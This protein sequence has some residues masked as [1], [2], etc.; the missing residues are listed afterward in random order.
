MAKQYKDWFTLD[1]RVRPGVGVSKAKTEAV[2]DLAAQAMRGS[3][4]ALGALTE[5]VTTSDA[6]FNLAH[7]VTLEVL[8]QLDEAPRVWSQIAGT[9]TVS[10]FRPVT[11]YSLNQEWGDG[12][13]GDGEPRHVSPTVPEGAPYPH[14]FLKGEE[15]QHA[16]VKKRGFRTGLTFEAWVNDA[17][18]VL[19]DLPQQMLE[20][21]RD[22]EEYEVFNA[23][24]TGVGDAQKIAGGTVIPSGATSVA[25]GPLTRDNLIAAMIQVADRT[26]GGRRI[27]V[28]ASWNLIVAPGQG[29]YANFILNQT[30]TGL[31][32]NPASGTP[33]YE[34]V[35]NGFN[36]L[37]GI[38]VVESE[39]VSGPAWYLVPKP[40]TTRRRVLDRLNMV[41]HTAP[42]LRVE[43]AT[44]TYVG[45]G[46]VSPFQGS[47]ETDE[48]SFRIRQ[49][50]GG[51]LWNPEYVVWSE[52]TGV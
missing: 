1:G 29:I 34:F 51:V 28:P 40:G 50:G 41:G 21:A 44:G 42:E 12:V 18:G 43:N 45:G 10:D 3:R 7:L 35:V 49:I 4:I 15:S 2:R 36:P 23:L 14:A 33:E 52:G 32:T 11:L 27:P 8:P 5:A 25:D 24:L 6:M 30:L 13:L 38:T 19:S 17:L 48:A 47:F 9:K 37:G 20:V 22:T 16:R 39:Y 46:T 26:I 31:N